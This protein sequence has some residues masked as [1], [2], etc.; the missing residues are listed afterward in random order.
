MAAV[1]WAHPGAASGKAAGYLLKLPG[2]D[3]P[4]LEITTTNRRVSGR[5]GIVVH[6]TSWLPPH[7]LCVLDHIPITSIERTVLDLCGIV[8]R[9]RGAI[10]LDHTLH[11]GMSTLGSYDFCLFLCARRGR[12]GCGILRELIKER[13]NLTQYPNSAL[14][15]VIF[16]MIAESTLPPP[17]MQLSIYDD[18]GGF[19]A[20]PDFVWPDEKLIV[21]GH[22]KLWH[23][24][25]ELEASDRSKHERLTALDYKI[26]YVTWADATTHRAGTVRTI[27]NSLLE[28]GWR[29][30]TA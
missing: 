26:L 5:C 20:R 3:Q 17:E 11:R 27:E 15:T 13:A 12:N 1:L 7:Q 4:P 9:R 2:F 10:A 30:W 16:E 14:E 18:R 6:Y 25:M 22:S 21:E 24:G 8:G 28:R 19:V 29:P 23:T